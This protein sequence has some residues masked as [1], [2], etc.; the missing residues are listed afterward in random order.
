M[1][2]KTHCFVGVV[3]PTRTK[4]LAV[5]SLPPLGLQACVAMLDSFLW[6]L[7]L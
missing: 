4:G 5:S 2:P 6:V 7:G 1:E 3:G